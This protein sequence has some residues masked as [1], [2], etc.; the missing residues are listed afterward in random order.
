MSQVCHYRII[1]DLQKQIAVLKQENDALKGVLKNNSVDPVP[2]L[3]AE[4]VRPL[5][6]VR[7]KARSQGKSKREVKQELA[8]AVERDRLAAEYISRHPELSPEIS[9]AIC[10]GKIVVGFPEDAFEIISSGSPYVASESASGKSIK[11]FLWEPYGLQ[12][13]MEMIQV[14]VVDGAVSHV[15]HDVGPPQ[16]PP[17]YR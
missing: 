7:V 13:T 15:F 2:A 11:L 9:T 6:S 17:T 12:S 16:S 5:Y 4:N 3:D 14:Q 8:D 10:E 1:A